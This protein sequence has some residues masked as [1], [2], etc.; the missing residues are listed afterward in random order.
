MTPYVPLMNG[1]LNYNHMVTNISTA[2][3]KAVSY[4]DGLVIYTVTYSEDFDLKTVMFGLK[5]STSGPF[6]A[7]LARN[8][9]FV[10]KASNGLYLHA[11]SD[12]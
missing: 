7:F 9:T 10:A 3:F 2:V 12:Y 1:G 6:S 5:P 8:V 4:S 11:Y